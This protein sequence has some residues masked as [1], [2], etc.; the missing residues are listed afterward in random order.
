MEQTRGLAPIGL[1]PHGEGSLFKPL[2]STS[3][4]SDF[5]PF[6]I[7]YDLGLLLLLRVLRRLCVEGG[8]DGK[9]DKLPAQREAH[10]SRTSVRRGEGVRA[11]RVNLGLWGGCA[12][13]S[14]QAMVD[15]G[16]VRRTAV[17]RA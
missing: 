6:F 13:L 7:F 17:A 9:S 11:G 2:Y 12:E 3:R 1:P 14:P 16:L 4:R 10:C 5:F 15:H 8:L